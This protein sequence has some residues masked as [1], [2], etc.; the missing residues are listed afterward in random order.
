[1]KNDINFVAETSSGL[2]NGIVNQFPQ[3]VCKSIAS[4][5]TDVHAWSLTDGL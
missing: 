2:I 5:S 1:M 3:K 4:G